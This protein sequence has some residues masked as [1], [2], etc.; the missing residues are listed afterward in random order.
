MI[1]GLF[2]VLLTIV[3]AS[4]GTGTATAGAEMPVACHESCGDTGAASMPSPCLHD[5]GCGAQLPTSGST[6]LALGVAA[7]AVGIAGAAQPSSRVA[8]RECA[9]RGREPRGR[10]F[11]PPRFT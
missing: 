11:R 5:A 1:A 3:T 2:V 6:M 4:V 8:P 10:L 7:A 9:V